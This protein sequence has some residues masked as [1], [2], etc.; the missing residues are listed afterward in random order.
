MANRA[1]TDRWLKTTGPFKGT[2]E[3]IDNACP[4]LRVRIGKR[5]KS[6]SVMI[7]SAANRRRIAI[8]H[9]PLVS[10]LDARKKATELLADPRAAG[11]GR[12]RKGGGQ[13]LGTVDELFKFTVS[14]MKAEGKAAS[15]SDYRLYLL[16]GANAATSDFGPSTLARNVTPAMV[17]DWLSKFHDRGK[18]TR[19][20][21]AILSAAFN[22]GLKAD[23]DPTSKKDQTILFSLDTNPVACVGGPTQ[24]GTRNRSLSLEEMS[25]FWRDLESDYFSEGLGV[26][27]KMI[28]AMGGVRVT[29]VVRSKKSWWLD[30]G[31]WRIL[32]S[33]KFALPETK[34][35]LPHDLPLTQCG[36]EVLSMARSLAG[37]NCVHLFPSPYKPAVPRSLDNLSSTLREYCDD[38]NFKSFTPRDIRRS[39]KN[40]LLDNDVAQT[41]VDIWHNHGRNADVARRNYDRSQYEHAKGRVRDAID[42]LVNG[43]AKS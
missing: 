43:L 30:D 17:T 34:N 20:P 32:K 31:G 19:L 35:G 14:A 27:F 6:F 15:V 21:R 23:N 1:F 11:G 8:G 10:L 18:S 5:K 16:D 22:R 24:S 7:G 13:R 12:P 28:I 25:Q 29:E 38:C 33:P 37:E 39:M 3:F 26:A 4:N 40:L 42:E 41:E 9:Y 2:K 36:V